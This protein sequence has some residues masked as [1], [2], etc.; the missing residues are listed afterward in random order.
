MMPRFQVFREVV[1]DTAN[2]V[3]NEDEPSE[4]VPDCCEGF[5]L[6]SCGTNARSGL[7]LQQ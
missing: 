6:E 3:D 2:H 4:L 5:T 1:P 7:V